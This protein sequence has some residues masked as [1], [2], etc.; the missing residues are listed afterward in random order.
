MSEQIDIARSLIGVPWRHQGRNAAVGIDCAGL[1]ILAFGVRGEKP[2]YGRNP[3]QGQM[4]A[5]LQLYL[6]QPLAEG[7]QVLPGDAVAMAYAGDIRH[8]GLIAGEP[9]ALTLIHTDSTLGRV[10]EHPLDTKW[11]RRIR[12]VYRRGDT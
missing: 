1:L 11:L 3:F 6:G 7:A 4:E 2:T 8:C 10:T 5:T 12:Q 9:G